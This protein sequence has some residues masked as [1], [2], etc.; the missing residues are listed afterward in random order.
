MEN[1][2]SSFAFLGNSGKNDFVL[3]LATL[4]CCFSV[5]FSFQYFYGDFTTNAFLNEKSTIHLTILLIPFA[6]FLILLLSFARLFH[7]RSIMSFITGQARFQLKKLLFCFS[8]WIL[9][10]S[11]VD[12]INY[13]VFGQFYTMNFHPVEFISLIAICLT[14]LVIQSATEEIF[15]RGY[16]LQSIVS[17]S[18]KLWMGVLV[19]SLLF[20]AL[21]SANPE[22]KE[23]GYLMMS[24]FYFITGLILVV[25]TILGNGLEIPIGIHAGINFYTAVFVN[26]DSSVLQ[27]ASLFNTKLNSVWPMLCSSIIGFI[28]LYFILKK[29]K[30]IEDVVSLIKFKS[31]DVTPV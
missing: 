20:L 30:W 24:S 14:L 2:R 1:K 23:F 19:T 7:K 26:Y 8:Y 27:T 4:F 3:Y 12:F 25:F 5:F 21:H 29:L 22:N 18:N 11:L 6:V 17:Q 16:M 10:N 13:K 9:F 28:L 31:N 15:I